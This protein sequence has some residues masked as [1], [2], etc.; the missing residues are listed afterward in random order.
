LDSCSPENL[1]HV[2][3]LGNIGSGIR[4]IAYEE[5]ISKLTKYGNIT[6]AEV[7]VE[8]EFNTQEII[9]IIALLNVERAIQKEEGSKYAF[10]SRRDRIRERATLYLMTIV[11]IIVIGIYLHSLYSVQCRI[12]EIL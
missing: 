11:C 1:E 4:I 12:N 8:K 7:K 6:Y 5:M 3:I 10:I 9:E 2:F